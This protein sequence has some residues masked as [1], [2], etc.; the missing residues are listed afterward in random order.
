[1]NG[2]WAAESELWATPPGDDAPVLVVRERFDAHVPDT[3]TAT[4]VDTRTW[5]K[6][7]VVAPCG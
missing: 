4:L 2:N 6:L 5:F 7:G 1:M 3:V